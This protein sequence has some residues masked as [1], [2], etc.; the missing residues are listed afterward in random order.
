MG[1]V[2]QGVHWA[3]HAATADFQYVGIDHGCSDICVTKQ[4]LHGTDVVP[5]LQH[6]RRK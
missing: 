3:A 6:S 1:Y 5:G 4:L 2:G